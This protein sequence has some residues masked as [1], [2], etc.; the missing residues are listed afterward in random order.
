MTYMVESMTIVATARRP[1]CVLQKSYN[2]KT[3]GNGSFRANSRKLLDVREFF[4]SRG[5]QVSQLLAV[6]SLC[7]VRT[8]TEK[9]ESRSVNDY[10]CR[11]EVL[12]EQ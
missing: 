3:T 8:A 1:P 9:V 2:H 10:E 12:V 7:M 5:H 11:L 6:C 4:D